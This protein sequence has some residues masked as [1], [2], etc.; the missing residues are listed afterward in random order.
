MTDQDIGRV[1]LSFADYL[2]SLLH[3]VPI[4]AENEDPA[5]SSNQVLAWPVSDTMHILRTMTGR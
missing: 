2:I 1:T 5:R 3:L 4:D